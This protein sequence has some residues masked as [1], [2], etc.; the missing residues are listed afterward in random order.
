M[1]NKLQ[2]Q[3]PDLKMPHVIYVKTFLP[4]YKAQ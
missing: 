4:V 3:I 2:R 1:A